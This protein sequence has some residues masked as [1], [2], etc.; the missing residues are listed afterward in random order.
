MTVGVIAGNAASINILN[1]SVDVPSISAATTAEVSVTIPG[2]RT[3][4]TVIAEKPS[5]SAGLL[6]GSCRVSAANTVQMQVANVTASPIN[7]A[8]ETYRFVI[9]GRDGGV[10]SGVER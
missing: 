9:I 3:T 4:D 6:V 2:V 10:V 5:L 7:P 1:I 8:A